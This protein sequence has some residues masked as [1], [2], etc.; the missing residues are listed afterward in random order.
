ME[1]SVWEL[2]CRAR[3]DIR[4]GRVSDGLALL[5]RIVDPKWSDV[6]EC[7]GQYR[8]FDPD[9]AIDNTHDFFARAL[10]MQIAVHC[11]EERA[12]PKE[13]R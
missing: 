3:D 13:W 9:G 12:E 8:M 10:G 7:D 1:E 2:V 11:G 5:D 6:S 4:A